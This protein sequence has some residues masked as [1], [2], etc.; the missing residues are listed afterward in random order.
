M[1]VELGLANQKLELPRLSLRLPLLLLGLCP[2]NLRPLCLFSQILLFP[3]MFTPKHEHLAHEP[4]GFH[5]GEFRSGDR[6]YVGFFGV[7]AEGVRELF[8]LE[9]F[10][11]EACGLEFVGLWKQ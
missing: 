6:A 2:I 5:L 10:G 11:L 4:F 7:R 8:G 1:T 3:I 9:D